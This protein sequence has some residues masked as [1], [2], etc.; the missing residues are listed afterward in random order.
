MAP[1]A[2][3]ARIE[4]NGDT[5]WWVH[6]TLSEAG[7][8]TDGVF[9][10]EYAAIEPL[11]GWV[12]RQNGRAIPLEPEDLRRGMRRGAQARAGGARGRGAEAGAPEVADDRRRMRSSG[13]RR[14]WLRS[15]SPS[16]RRCSRI[17]LPPAVTDGLQISTRTSSRRASRS[18]R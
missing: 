15:A 11:A 17:C 10:T 4:V 8:L 18:P 14:R 2:G 9:E 16:S 12:L 5:A 3:T 1:V 7:T 6:R 13:R